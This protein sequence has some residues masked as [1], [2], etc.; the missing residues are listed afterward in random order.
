MIDRIERLSTDDLPA[1][2]ALAENREWLPEAHKWRLL[3]AVGTVYGLRDEAGD[4][5]ATA[6]LTRYGTRLAAISMVL[7]ASRYGRRG[8]GGRLM[9]H[10]LDEAGDATVFLNATPYGRPLYE[11]LG[12]VPI[13]TTHTH[14]GRLEPT[15]PAAT[16]PAVPGDLAMLLALDARV[17][18]ADRSH[19]LR[20]LPDFAECVRVVERRGIV[21]GYA[22]AWRNVDNVVIGPVIAADAADARALIGDIAATIDGPVRLDLD[23]RHP[24]L[25]RWAAGRG[26][27]EWGSTTVM[28][29][30]APELPGDR[31]RWFVPLMQALG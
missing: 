19:V 28:V 15:G 11:R 3:F 17:N 16:R 4:V 26:V 13:G 9:T 23:G 8:L 18:G 22:A 30:G 1:C 14:V 6:I 21:S 24:E 31:D 29:Y 25:R 5:V 2:L 12:F 7:V 27:P 20:T 10:L